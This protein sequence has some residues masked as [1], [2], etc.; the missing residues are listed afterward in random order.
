MTTLTQIDL[1]SGYLAGSDKEWKVQ[2]VTSLTTEEKQK[3]A[4]LYWNFLQKE[5]E[6]SKAITTEK[7]GVKWANKSAKQ[8]KTKKETE[9]LY[10]RK[11]L[12]N[13]LLS[14]LSQFNTKGETIKYSKEKIKNYYKTG[15]I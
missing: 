3:W 6:I 12:E 10:K 8:T 9:L 2:G 5:L 1:S 7:H 11:T 14:L 4:S 13:F 15:L